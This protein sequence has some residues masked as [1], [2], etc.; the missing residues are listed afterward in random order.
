MGVVEVG[1]SL[2]VPWIDAVEAR[3]VVDTGRDGHVGKKTSSCEK[4]QAS[5]MGTQHHT[6]NPIILFP[7]S[8]SEDDALPWSVHCSSLI[9]KMI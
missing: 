5:L 7:S 3:A 2:P 8:Q 4:G 1:Y 9:I 6:W